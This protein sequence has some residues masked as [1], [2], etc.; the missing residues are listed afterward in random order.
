MDV[1]HLADPFP[2]QKSQDCIVVGGGNHIQKL[3]RKTLDGGEKNKKEND[4]NTENNHVKCCCT[5]I[6]KP[7][8]ED[9]KI[10]F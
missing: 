1:L 10:S 5:Q 4:E 7:R 3:Q 2:A 8:V 6:T 9:L